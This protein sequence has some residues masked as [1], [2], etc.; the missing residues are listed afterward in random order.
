MSMADAAVVVL[1]S[2]LNPFARN[3]T[4]SSEL[5]RGKG[6]S[7]AQSSQLIS[8]ALLDPRFVFVFAV[9]SMRGFYPTP[10]PAAVHVAAS[11]RLRA[12][13]L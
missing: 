8:T 10:A 11:R 6:V 5:R 1:A 7:Y 12:G 9:H 3:R 13:M 2:R 4:A